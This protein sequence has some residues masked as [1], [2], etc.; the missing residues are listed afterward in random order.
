MPNQ[1][2]VARR[3]L[4]NFLPLAAFGLGKPPAATADVAPEGPVSDTSTDPRAFGVKADGVMDDTEAWRRWIMHCRGLNI[5]LSC[6][7]QLKSKI[8][9]TLAISPAGNSATGVTIAVNLDLSNIIFVYAGKRDRPALDIG[10]PSAQFSEASFRLPTVVADGNLSWDASV[11][12]TAATTSNDVGIRIHRAYRVTF[13]ESYISGFTKGIEYVGVAYCT[14]FG[15]H[16][17]DCKYGRVYN[18]EGAMP[19]TSFTNENIVIGGRLGTTSRSDALGDAFGQVFTWDKAASY[20]GQNS[21]KFYG[22][23]FEM[24]AG[25]GSY[26][27]PVLM[28]GAGTN[29]IFCDTRHESGKGPYAL[30][31]GGGSRAVYASNNRFHVLYNE[32]GDGQYNCIK[33]VNYACGN[34]Y[35]GTGCGQESWHSGDIGKHIHSDGAEG[36]YIGRGEIFCYRTGTPSKNIPQS[37][38]LAHRRSA[39]LRSGGCGL[40]GVA[41]DAS[42]IKNFRLTA[43]TAGAF[44]G[45]IVIHCFDSSGNALFGLATDAI[46]G[47]EPYA[48]ATVAISGGGAALLV[49]EGHRYSTGNDGP[50]NRA[51]L[52]TLREEVAV[53]Y[54]LYEGGTNHCALQSIGITGFATAGT[55]ASAYPDISGFTGLRVF[56]P[57]DDPGDLPLANA[58]P[59]IAGIIGYYARGQRVGNDGVSTIA[60][61]GWICST[62]GWLAPAWRP[63]ASYSL[64]GLLVV[65]D[66]GNIYELTA[67]GSS[68]G[69]GG[70]AGTGGGI[71]DG[72]CTWKHIGSRA[73]FV[74]EAVTT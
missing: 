42:R 13:E 69:R 24:G 39:V 65:N 41:V 35:E 14:I 37:Q 46:W 5:P 55:L 62:S 68:A 74:T 8:T 45:R 2:G 44:T 12:P 67:P 58:K 23:C 30:C 73:V 52:L 28:D 40:I 50:V 7:V 70:P 59:D 1:R 31:I 57:T 19:D 20:R 27:V 15:R 48:K 16:I 17:C 43:A 53:A 26:R 34:I 38:I 51:V 29:N 56:S 18:T 21:N 61:A 66:A 6:P 60:T 49:V 36:A 9:D 25:T 72:S 3:T 54:I 10:S 64:P 4:F 47:N 33:Q 63:S 71:R 32:G 11:T 22:V